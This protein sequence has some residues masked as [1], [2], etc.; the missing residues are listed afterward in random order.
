M[1]LTSKTP[2]L[3]VNKVINVN[4]KVLYNDR[5]RR[6]D[7][8]KPIKDLFEDEGSEVFYEMELC[9]NTE[10]IVERVKELANEKIIPVIMY[11]KVRT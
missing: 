1:T 4:G 8:K 7:L 3:N 10:R 6:I 5:R 2:I 11:F 9:F